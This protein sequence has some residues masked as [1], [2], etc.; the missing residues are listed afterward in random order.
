MLDRRT[1]NRTLLLRQHLLERSSLSAM[2]MVEHLA[3]MQAQVPTSPY[4][5]LWSRIEGF[6]TDDLAAL[7]LERR[8]VRLA[9]MRSTI[10][11]VTA[12]DALAFRPVLAAMLAKDPYAR[13]APVDDIVRATREIVGG[14]PRTPAD[15]A[16]LLVERFPTHDAEA[17]GHAARAFVALVQVP[18]RGVWGVGGQVRLTTLESWVDRP[19]GSSTEHD[20]LV[21]RYL[22][23]FGPAS[24]KDF[25]AWSRFTGVRAAFD[26]LRPQLR[27]DRDENGVELFDTPDAP[28]AE[29]DVATPVRFLPE[30]DNVLLAHA[31][32][33]RIIDERARSFLSRENGYW[34]F[35]LVDGRVRATWSRRDGSIT[36]SPFDEL[37]RA[38]HDAVVEEGEQLAAAF[39][40]DRVVVGQQ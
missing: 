3:G 20:E 31:D 8:V 32:R 29:P 18:P 33:T 6:A 12:G 21:L 1:L 14:E 4:A 36:V 19:L 16:Q 13:G 5:G 11:L 2:E 39:D 34:P 23:A 22:R 15:L 40:A 30:Y 25:A 37:T 10:H 24:T 27:I 9:L 38:E 28:I 26:R 17:L 7:L 35:V